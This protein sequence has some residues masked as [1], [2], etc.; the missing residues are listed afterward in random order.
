M[1]AVSQTNVPDPIL[2]L[3]FCVG[4]HK[5]TKKHLG[6]CMVFSLLADCFVLPVTAKVRQKIHV[7]IK[8]FFY[9]IAIVIWAHIEIRLFI[10][11]KLE[12][13]L[14]WK[15][16]LDLTV[17]Y[18][19]LL[20]TLL[21]CQLIEE[22]EQFEANYALSKHLMNLVCAFCI[23]VQHGVAMISGKDA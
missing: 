21:Y 19:P 3:Q 22:W 4:K 17:S 9:L 14:H 10:V 11:K 23:L 8:S 12:M 7:F 6:N 18:L 2:V 13:A 15:A 1:A 5:T 20:G 16:C